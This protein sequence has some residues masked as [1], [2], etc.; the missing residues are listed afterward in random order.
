LFAGKEKLMS[1]GG[2][3]MATIRGLSLTRPWPFAFVNAGAETEPK[4]IENRSWKPPAFII[5]NYVALHAAQSWNEDDRDWIQHMTGLVVPRKA[6]HPHSEIFAVCRV[7]GYVTHPHDERVSINQRMWFFGEY[8][9]LL[10]DLVKLVEPVPCAGGLGLWKFDE[11]PAELYALRLSYQ[12]SI[13]SRS[14]ER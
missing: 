14:Q 5:N 3:D 8:G 6:E 13:V 7:V 12:K 9:W 11:R 10:D 1:V 2:W 4:L